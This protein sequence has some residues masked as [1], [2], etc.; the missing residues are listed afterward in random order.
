LHREQVTVS[1]GVDEVAAE[2]GNREHPFDDDR[3]HEESRHLQAD[4]GQHR[5]A[6]VPQSV[7][8]E[9]EVRGE[10]FRARGAQE[11]LALDLE[12]G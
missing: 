11:V 3:A 6:R 9:R 10:P 8:H 7:A 4:D 2:S 12:H 1:D 5:D